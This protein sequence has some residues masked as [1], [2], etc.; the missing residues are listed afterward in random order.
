M[1]RVG[2][3]F[4]R[5]V[6]LSSLAGA[7]LMAAPFSA[8]AQIR[9]RPP[10][11]IDPPND[12]VVQLPS[13]DIR[14]SDTE[15]DNLIRVVQARTQ[16]SV[17][18]TGTTLAVFDTGLRT[19][20]VDFAG[21][22][23]TQVNFTAD[24]GGNVND[25]TDGNG[26]GT[27]VA[28]VALGRGIHTGIAP[29]ANVI[30]LKVLSNTGGGSFSALQLALD[31]V[32]A[33]R[34]TFN[35][36][37]CN[38][39][40]GAFSN[41]IVDFDPATD[42][43]RARIQTLAAVNVPVIISAGNDFFSFGSQQGMSYPAITREAISVGAVFDANI[44]SVAYGSGAVAFTS[45]PRRITPFSQRLH[46]SLA[47]VTRTD[48]FA[49][50]ARLTAAGIADD[51][52]SS[53]FDG[54]SQA[55]PVVAGLVLLMQEYALRRT[56]QLPTVAQLESWLRVSTANTNMFDGDDEDDNVINTNL[57]YLMTD[58]LDSLTREDQDIAPP[59]P[60]PPSSVTASFAAGVLTL[61]GD[62]NASNLTITRRGSKAVIQCGTGTSVNGK[63]SV[64]FNVGSSPV[65]ITGNLLGGNDHTT[66]VLM[67]VS[68][69]S[70][71]LGDGN[72]KLILNYCTVGNSQVNGGPGTDTFISTTSSIT[73]LANT[74]I[75]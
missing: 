12:R 65:V 32:I 5:A 47:P 37:A 53:M 3:P 52:A 33:N 17:D 50:G 31:W 49:P 1:Q 74:N 13:S 26:H 66:L 63:S 34:T 45:G 46:P 73:T 35:I 71:N 28:G 57:D 25:A 44:G 18:G 48:I 2:G 55:A 8:E 6:V 43:I 67:R 75:P 41:E 59:P 38:M 15:T 69:L 11:V 51:M 62:N 54:T 22:V 30:P 27:N 64:Q 36:T 70:L 68:T 39:S 72:D 29:G 42:P 21:K 10:T 7:A 58:A 16:F 14:S 24:N 19:T 61:T 40:L 20:H 23:T 56:G 60:P 9:R 4:L